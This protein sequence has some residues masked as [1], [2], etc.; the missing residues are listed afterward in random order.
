MP[1][2]RDGPPVVGEPG[3]AEVGE[4]GHLGERVAVLADRDGGEEPGRDPRLL[5]RALAQGTQDRAVVHHRVGVR[6]PEDHA[7]AACGRRA[8][9]GVDV[10][11]VLA[12]GRAQVDVRVDERRHRDQPVAV[13]HLGA[14]GRRQRVAELRHLAVAEQDVLGAVEARARVEQPG[15]AD[16]DVG[17]R[18]RGG[19]E[20][21]G[22]EAGR[23]HAAPIGSSAG[24]AATGVGA[25]DPAS[26]S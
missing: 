12:P 9:T 18:G 7:E 22:V 19:V 23:H 20:R 6:L 4:L 26:S 10:L 11:L 1:G 8:G 3:R 14:L 25:P 5:A 13:D 24:S 16:Q 21:R 2:A 17:R 15:A